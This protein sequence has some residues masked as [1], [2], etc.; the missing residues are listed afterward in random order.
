MKQL[1]IRLFIVCLLFGFYSVQS[2]TY[3]VEGVVKDRETNQPVFGASIILKN[4][5][6]GTSADEHGAFR[7][8]V[9]RFPAVLFIQCIGFL[10]DTLTIESEERYNS[11]YR[12]K[13]FTITLK[14]NPI[15]I[16]E[17]QI[18]AR[19]TLFEKDPYVIIDYAGL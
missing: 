13:K 14:S 17:V 7:L 3:M 15:Q 8:D 6:Q 16:G 12:N 9:M 4:C 11:D 19:S 2:Q 5:S 18:K 1:T 10:R